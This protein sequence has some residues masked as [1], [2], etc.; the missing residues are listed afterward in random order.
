LD[1]LARSEELAVKNRGMM[2]PADLS[3]PDAEHVLIGKA[4]KGSLDAFNQLVLR[5]QDIAYHHAY[6]LLGDA[7]SAEDITQDSFIKAYLNIRSF[8]GGSFRAWLLKIVTNRAYDLLRQSRNHPIQSLFPEDDYGEEI[9]SPAWSADPSPSVEAT[10]E[11][12]EDSRR[13]HQLLDELPDVYRTILVLV[14]LYELEYWEAAEI[15]QVPLGT[16][17]SRLARA[18]LRLWRKLQGNFEYF[19]H[20]NETVSVIPS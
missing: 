11:Q 9:E 19:I 4:S 20:F 12:N 8:R 7:A 2:K 18:R 16:V 1:F 17:K 6:A 14:D 10:V 5:Y 3:V 13:L 15:L